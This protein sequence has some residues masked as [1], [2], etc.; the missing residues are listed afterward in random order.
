MTPEELKQGLEAARQ[1]L[2]RALAGVTEE[3]FKRRPP[4]ASGDEEPWSIAE[5]LSH[6]LA[7]ERLWCARIALALDKDGSAV[8]PSPPEAHAAGARAGRS[9]P[10]PQIIHGLLASRREADLLIDRAATMEGGLARAVWHSRLE[11]RLTIEWML[12]EKVIDHEQEHGAQ[13]ESLRP[14]VGAPAVSA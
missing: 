4:V 12:Q 14:L 13:I 2:L 9:V 5:V 8:T 10:V 11:A 6:L 7:S 1:R 3:Q